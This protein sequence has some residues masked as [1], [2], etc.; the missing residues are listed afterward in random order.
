M[1]EPEAVVQHEAEEAL[2]GPDDSFAIDDLDGVAGTTYSA[3]V[4]TSCVA[5][6]R[7]CSLADELLGVV[8]VLDLDA[9]VGVVTDASRSVECVCAQSVLVPEDRE[10]PIRTPQD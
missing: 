6:E 2:L 5:R 10:P 8:V 4:L 1:G 3:S 7:E 9:V